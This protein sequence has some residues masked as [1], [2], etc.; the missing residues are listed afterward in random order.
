MTLLGTPVTPALENVHT[1]F[2]Y[3]QT[4]RQTDGRTDSQAHNVAYHWDGCI[5]SLHTIYQNNKRRTLLYTFYSLS[6]YNRGLLF[7]VLM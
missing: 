4:D 5:I 2:G 7:Y 1:V 6:I 3:G